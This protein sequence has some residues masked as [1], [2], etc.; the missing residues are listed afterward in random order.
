MREI[1]EESVA[2]RRFQMLL[3]A[4]FAAAAL[5]LAALGTYG[6]VSY[7]V[8]LR[9]NEMGIRMALG[10]SPSAL[11][12]M[13]LKQAMI[14]VIA[15]LALG[16]ITALMAGRLVRSMLYDV[17]PNDPA[18]ITAVILLLAGVGLAGAWA[19]AERAVKVNPLVVLHDE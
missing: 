13:V 16:T 7:A 19:P 6:V 8:A 15:G 3:S 5:L 17:S 18:I 9:T 4:S 1:L 14:P 11:R 2:Q 10:A 12:R